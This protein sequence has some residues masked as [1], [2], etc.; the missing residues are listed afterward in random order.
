MK[1]TIE[2]YIEQINEL[3]EYPNEGYN[4]N[5]ISSN[6]RL[7]AE[8]YG[9]FKANEIINN[10]K[11]N[12]RV[13]IEPVDAEMDIIAH[14]IIKLAGLKTDVG[15]KPCVRIVEHNDKTCSI[16]IARDVNID[17]KSEIL[18]HM[19]KAAIFYNN[20]SFSISNPDSLK[21]AAKHLKKY[22]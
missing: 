13:G 6:L 20:K 4:H 17:V 21:L 22:V 2:E 12:K 1:K 3:A 5:I 10:L 19:R 18:I 15:I 8:K 16:F 14:E 7:I 11:L 9:K